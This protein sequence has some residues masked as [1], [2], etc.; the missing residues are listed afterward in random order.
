[1]EITRTHSFAYFFFLILFLG[2]NSVPASA[3]GE[4]NSDNL[5]QRFQTVVEKTLDE[6]ELMLSQKSREELDSIVLR[7][8]ELI[9]SEN[10]APA[11]ITVAEANLVRL[12]DDFV[13]KQAIVLEDPAD[14]ATAM[15]SD[16]T[17]TE[18]SYEESISETAEANSENVGENTQEASWCPPPRLWPW[19]LD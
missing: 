14:T 18:G 5:I 17:E 9:G 2:L 4:Q 8:V 7:G 3:Q 13:K 10:A 1:M 19:C 16:E 12:I 15:A 11:D 6:R